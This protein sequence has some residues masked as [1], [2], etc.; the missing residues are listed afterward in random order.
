MHATIEV[1]LEMGCFL[2]GACQYVGANTVGAVS[3]VVLANEQWHEHK[4]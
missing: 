2:C 1:L 4:S 3:S